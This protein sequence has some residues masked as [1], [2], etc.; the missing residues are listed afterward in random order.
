MMRLSLVVFAAQARYPAVSQQ[1][2]DD[3]RVHRRAP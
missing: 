2:L 1:P 3:G